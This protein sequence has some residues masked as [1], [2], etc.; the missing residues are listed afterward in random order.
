MLASGTMGRPL[1]AAPF[2][3]PAR[4]LGQHDEVCAREHGRAEV[5]RRDRLAIWCVQSGSMR[6]KCTPSLLASVAAPLP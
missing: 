3:A 6:A 2:R 4:E 5:R 1:T